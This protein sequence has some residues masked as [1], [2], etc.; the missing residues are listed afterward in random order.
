MKS[1][2]TKNM[3]STW[4]VSQTV[5]NIVANSTTNSWNVHL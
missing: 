2:Q 5:N 1:D 4:K 3:S